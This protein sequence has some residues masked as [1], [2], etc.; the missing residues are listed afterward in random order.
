MLVEVKRINKE[1]VT[2][3]TS[4][5]VAETFEKNHYDVMDSIRNIES[6]ISTTEFSVLFNLT[7]YKASNGK[8]NPMYCVTRDGFTLLVIDKRTPQF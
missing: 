7:S 5:D 3:V 6:S 1:E 8:S 4:L 2:V